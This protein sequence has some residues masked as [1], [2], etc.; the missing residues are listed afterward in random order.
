[1]NRRDILKYTAYATG[2][3]VCTP[4]LSSILSGC[5]PDTTNYDADFMPQFFSEEE[6]RTVNGLIDTILP[7]TSSPAASEVGVDKTIDVMVGTV[8]KKA[9]REAFRE[10]FLV[11]QEFLEEQGGGKAFYKLSAEEKLKLLKQL[12]SE[13]GTADARSAYLELKQQTV[14]YYL[15]TEEVAKNFLNFLPIPGGYEACIPLVDV[16]GKAWAL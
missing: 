16:G 15:S 8:Y 13:E 9:D 10:R 1:M 2:A 14:A 11:L 5:M 6:F 4:L 12:E 3:A 7:K